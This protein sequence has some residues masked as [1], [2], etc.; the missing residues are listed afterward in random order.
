MSVIA[1]TTFTL[2]G[3]RHLEEE[4][5]QVSGLAE[6]DRCSLP[7][8][9]IRVALYPHRFALAP[10]A[11]PQNFCMDMKA[12]SGRLMNFN[13]GSSRCPPHNEG[14]TLHRYDHTWVRL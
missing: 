3:R 1:P 6:M 8:L 13:K 5:D 10:V 11:Q 14:S 7:D 12:R 4:D 9:R 2:P